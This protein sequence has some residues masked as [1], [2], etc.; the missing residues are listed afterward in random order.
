MIDLNTTKPGD[1]VITNQNL[2]GSY[3]LG[4]LCT[5]EKIEINR[6]N[7][8][9]SQVHISGEVGFYWAFRFDNMSSDPSKNWANL[10]SILARVP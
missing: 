8:A 7:S 6:T 3:S 4:T 10:L 2:G 9:C 5:V 1:T